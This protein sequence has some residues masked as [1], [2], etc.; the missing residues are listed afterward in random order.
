MV[1]HRFLDHVMSEI[2][3]QIEETFIYQKIDHKIF[4]LK[5]IKITIDYY[6]FIKLLSLSLSV[7]C[8]NFCQS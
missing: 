5:K 2:S 6:R 7:S 3:K 1:D 4:N 8:K